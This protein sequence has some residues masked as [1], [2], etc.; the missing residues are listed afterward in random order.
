MKVMGEKS[1]KEQVPFDPILSKRMAEISGSGETWT[2]ENLV[3]DA[4]K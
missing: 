3:A 1:T 2:I 4:A